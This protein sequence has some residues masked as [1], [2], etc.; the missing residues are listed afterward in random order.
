M[1]TREFVSPAV[2]LGLRVDRETL[3]E[4]IQRRVE[5]MWADG[6]R[7]ETEG[8]LERGLRG[9]V[10]A[11]RAIGYSQAIAVIDGAMTEAEARDDTAQATRRYARRQ[12]AWFRPEPRVT[13]LEASTAVDAAGLVAPALEAIRRSTA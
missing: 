1:P 7:G 8:L 11:S 12:D 9:G 6:L 10:T 4:R 13:W 3:A 2:L 5:R